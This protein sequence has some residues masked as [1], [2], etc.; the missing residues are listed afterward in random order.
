MTTTAKQEYEAAREELRRTIKTSLEWR[1]RILQTEINNYYRAD[2]DHDY[3]QK[4]MW[5]DSVISN[6]DGISHRFKMLQEL[7]DNKDIK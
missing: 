1:L 5:L 2:A 3:K 4:R 6:I 7:V